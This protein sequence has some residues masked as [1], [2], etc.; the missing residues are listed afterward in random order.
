MLDWRQLRRWGIAEGRV[1]PGSEVRYR[2][3]SLWDQYRGPVAGALAVGAAQAA[4]IAGLLVERA[5]PRAALA[6]R[7]GRWP[8]ASGDLEARTAEVRALAGRLLVAQEEERTAIARE[9]HDEVGQALTT[10][11]INLD[12]MRVVGA[13]DPEA[14]AE[15]LDD[16]VQLVDEALEQVRDLSLLLHPAMLDHLGLEAALRWLLH[17][18][19]QRAGYE[20]SYRATPLAPPP[21]PAA[22]LICYRVAQ[23]ALTNV[24]RHARASHVRV[25]LSAAGGSAAPGRRRRRRRVRSGGDARAGPHRRQHGAA[26]PRGARRAR[27]WRPA[28]GHRSRPGHHADPAIAPRRRGSGRRPGAGA[29]DRPDSGPGAGRLAPAAPPGRM[30]SAVSAP[31]VATAPAVDHHQHLFSPATAA[32]IG[33]RRDRR[34]SA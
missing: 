15:L 32:L 8:R 20:V 25:D 26:E 31:P 22:A 19:S 27:R 16:G 34:R 2:M 14:Q 33:E 21:S 4:L 6:A 17:S 13:G 9:L 11:K 7:Q 12:T 1:P 29:G 23:E 3:P 5:R 10:I 24:A 28:T 18:Q 30:L